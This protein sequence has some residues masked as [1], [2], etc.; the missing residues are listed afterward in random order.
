[1]LCRKAK[2]NCNLEQRE[3]YGITYIN[4]HH[5]KLHTDQLITASQCKSITSIRPIDLPLSEFAEGG[6][7]YIK[8]REGFLNKNFIPL[9]IMETMQ[10]RLCYIIDVP[11]NNICKDM[12]YCTSMKEWQAEAKNTSESVGPGLLYWRRLCHQYRAHVAPILFCSLVMLLVCVVAVGLT[13]GLRSICVLIDGFQSPMISSKTLPTSKVE[14]AEDTPGLFSKTIV[15][16][17]T[18]I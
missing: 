3:Y 13:Y 11:T 12:Y 6:R 10:M 8:F 17:D 7:K 1:M 18:Q 9:E 2:T 16:H 14:N 5:R 15:K 4:F